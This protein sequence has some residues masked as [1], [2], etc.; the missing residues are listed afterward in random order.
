MVRFFENEYLSQ[1]SD[2]LS[3]CVFSP[4]QVTRVASTGL[5][6]LKFSVLTK[7]EA[8]AWARVMLHGM[9]MANVGAYMDLSDLQG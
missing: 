4:H 3:L 6:K 9:L 1:V 5:V 2:W 7:G 8:D